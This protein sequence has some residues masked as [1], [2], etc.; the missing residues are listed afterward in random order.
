M[1]HKYFPIYQCVCKSNTK[2]LFNCVLKNTG[3]KYHNISCLLC[4]TFLYKNSCIWFIAIFCRCVAYAYLYVIHPYVTFCGSNIMHSCR[5]SAFLSSLLLHAHT[6][7]FLVFYIFYLHLLCPVSLSEF[8]FWGEY[9][10][11]SSD[12]VH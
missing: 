5:T 4:Y 11:L 12:T 9:Y 2:Y 6:V 1:H 7:V 3:K 10:I 8:F